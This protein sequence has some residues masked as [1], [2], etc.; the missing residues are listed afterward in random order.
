MKSH[1]EFTSNLISKG[2]SFVKSQ[3]LVDDKVA[4]KSLDQH[5]NAIFDLAVA[6]SQVSTASCFLDFAENNTDR[7]RALADL[8]CADVCADV[9]SRLKRTAADFG[10]SAEDFAGEVEL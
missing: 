10:L 5:Q 4:N 7:D 9:V 3:C 2:L 1:I 6:Y 8:F